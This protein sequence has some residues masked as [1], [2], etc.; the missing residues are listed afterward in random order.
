MMK[1]IQLIICI[2]GSEAAIYYGKYILH[3]TIYYFIV[4]SL[5]WAGKFAEFHSAYLHAAS[6]GEM[7]T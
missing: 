1:V 7:S 3:T 4:I 6:H 5:I 2:I